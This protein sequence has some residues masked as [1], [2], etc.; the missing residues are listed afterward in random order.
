MV[1][2]WGMTEK[3]GVI[4]YDERGEGGRYLGAQ[5]IQEKAYSEETAT[6]I[7]NEV[8]KIIGS[9]YEFA[10]TIILAH[11]DQ[12][13]LMTDMLMEFETLDQEDVLLIRD[14]KWDQAKKKEKETI[15]E[16]LNRKVPPPPP[17]K[18]EKTG[19]PEVFK[20]PTPEVI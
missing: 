12:L 14:G 10:K 4:A 15:L 7:D 20:D 13:Q 11:R 18:V 9:A 16:N 2:E 8:R 1:C 6:A 3:L 17:P 19:G 5:S